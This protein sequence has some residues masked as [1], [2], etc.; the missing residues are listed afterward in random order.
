MH[1]IMVHVVIFSDGFNVKEF[2]YSLAQATTEK[3]STTY[4]DVYY[5]GHT[6]Q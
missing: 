5:M 2:H 4:P 3:Q 1:R 6:E